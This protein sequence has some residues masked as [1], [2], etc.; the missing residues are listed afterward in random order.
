MWL[1]DW[2]L[3]ISVKLGMAGPFALMGYL[4]ERGAIG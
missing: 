4:I 1:L 2:A 3:T